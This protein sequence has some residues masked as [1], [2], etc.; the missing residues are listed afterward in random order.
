LGPYHSSARPK[1]DEAVFRLIIVALPVLAIGLAAAAQPLDP[2]RGGIVIG[3][4]SL[5]VACSD[6]AKLAGEGLMAPRF[7]VDT[8]TAA[9]ES[10]ALT[11]QDMA[12][13][14]INRG[15][16]QLT[17][18]GA[19]EDARYDF[20]AAAQL[21][22]DLGESYANRGAA[23][24]AEERFAEAIVEIERGMSLGLREPWKAHFNRALA[25][26]R[27]D[28]VRGAYLDYQA[29]LELRPGWEMAQQ[30]LARFQVVP[31]PR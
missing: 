17:M 15:V 5:S 19:A 31:A 14:H 9:L 30:E 2:V 10:E 11:R 29:A 20:E 25:R 1:E 13:A 18:L 3:R 22:P 4:N 27:S 23:L 16:V 24:V 8:C 6:H 21:D 28:D 7:A 12:T 26:E